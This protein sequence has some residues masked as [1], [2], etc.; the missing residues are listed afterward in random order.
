MKRNVVRSRSATLM[1]RLWV[2]LLVLV[3]ACMPA[4]GDPSA[5]HSTTGAGSPFVPIEQ[6][7]YD[8][9][10]PSFDPSK[11]PLPADL[12]LADTVAAGTIAGAFSVSQAG[13]ATYT[14]PLV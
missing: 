12:P 1:P 5:G 14:L 2:L 9:T 7:A 3:A 6:F 4:G 13:E 10:C 8:V 11:S